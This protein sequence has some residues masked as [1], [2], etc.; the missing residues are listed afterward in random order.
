MHSYCPTQTHT[1]PPPSTPPS[2]PP[3]TAQLHRC[4]V[5]WRVYVYRERVLLEKLR[6]LLVPEPRPGLARAGIVCLLR[7]GPPS[8]SAS[9]RSV[10][11]GR[12][13]SL[14]SAGTGVGPAGAADSGLHATI[15]DRVARSKS[16]CALDDALWQSLGCAPELDADDADASMAGSDGE[17]THDVDGEAGAV[18]T[19]SAS[20]P[21]SPGRRRDGDVGSGRERVGDASLDA[22]R[23][24]GGET[25]LDSGR[26]GAGA[27]ELEAAL[28]HILSG[29]CTPRS[30]PFSLSLFGPLTAVSARPR[31]SAFSDTT[32]LVTVPGRALLQMLPR[33]SATLPHVTASDSCYPGRWM[34][35]QAAIS[36]S[37]SRLASGSVM[38]TS[39]WTILSMT[40]CGARASMSSLSHAQTVRRFSGACCRRLWWSTER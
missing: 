26:G 22:S 10:R 14:S 16:G 3:L 17:P 36:N 28:G 29:G 2:P 15:V 9:M 35:L 13:G 33:P 5:A 39:R 7:P 32:G 12:A 23:N 40:S 4:L 21:S 19:R 6:Q 24:Y 37:P 1:P 27:C 34:A 25:S 31:G 38:L 11:A 30:F 8:R 18:D 20:G